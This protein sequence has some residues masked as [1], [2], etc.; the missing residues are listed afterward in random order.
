MKFVFTEQFNQASAEEYFQYQRSARCKS[1]SPSLSEF[2]YND[3]VMGD[4]ESWGGRGV[5]HLS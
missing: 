2:G 5:V 1:D 3:E 4:W